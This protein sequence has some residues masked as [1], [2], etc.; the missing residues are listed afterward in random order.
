MVIPAVGNSSNAA[1]SAHR[2]GL[3]AASFTNVGNDKRGQE[4]LEAITEEG[5]TTEYVSVQD[6]KFTNYHFVLRFGPERTILVRHE[7]YDY[8]LPNFEESPSW[9]YFSSIGENAVDFHHD[10]VKYVK[11]NG[12]KLVFQPGTFQIKLGL[13]KLRDVYQACELF[14]CN[15]EEAQRILQTREEDIKEILKMMHEAGPK[16]CLYH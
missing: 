6:G 4:I 16:Y 3:S 14:F 10:V 12:T 15:K 13:D 8:Q 11:E 9:F 1:V 2:L 7:D 5:M